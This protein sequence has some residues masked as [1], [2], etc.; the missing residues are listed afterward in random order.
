MNET[1]FIELYSQITECS[2][3]QARSVYIVLSDDTSSRVNL[4]FTPQRRRP[5]QPSP[6]LPAL[7]SVAIEVARIQP[8]PAF[9][10]NL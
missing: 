10:S 8:A 5:A 2:E 9:T 3:N 4:L 1:R 6:S 7:R